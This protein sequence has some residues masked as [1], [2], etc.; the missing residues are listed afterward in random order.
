MIPA[1]NAERE[2]HLPGGL[3]ALALGAAVVLCKWPRR[4]AGKHYPG[5]EEQSMV[6][7]S[8]LE[9]GRAGA[10]PAAIS[11]HYDLSEEFFRLWLGPE[12]IYSCALF[13]GTQDLAEAQRRKLDYHIA[14]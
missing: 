12:L 3:G 10:S 11:A 13:E 7:Y 4:C 8:D 2:R 6:Q 1:A 14:A 5:A 9:D